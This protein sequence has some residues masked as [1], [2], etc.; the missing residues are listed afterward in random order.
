MTEILPTNLS[1]LPPLAITSLLILVLAGL[2]KVPFGYSLRNMLVRWRTTLV[3][4]L[5][6]T[7]V[8]GLLVVML[9]FVNGMNRL[10]DNTGSPAN[11]IILAE[12]ATDEVFSRMPNFHAD[13]LPSY[14]KE[15][16]ATGANDNYLVSAEV[17]VLVNQEVA[18]PKPGGPRRRFIQMRGVKDVDATARVHDMQLA[19]G[20]WFTDKIHEQD[21]VVNGEVVR[22]KE[23]VPEAVFG[24]GV[25]RVVG[26]DFF[27]RP[28]QP[29]DVV[30]VGPKWWH[31]TGVMRSEGSTFS[32]EV[33]TRDTPIQE[34]FGRPNSYSS[35]V[36][37]AKSPAMAQLAVQ[38]LKKERVAEMSLQPY[39]EREY[40]A[41]L[42][43]T[44]QQFSVAIYF[45]AVVMAIG[46]VLGVMN[47]MFAAIS[48]RQRDI[49]VLRLLGFRRGEILV[50]FLLE[51]VVIALLGGL[52]GCALGFLANG[53]SATSV[54]SSGAGGGGKSVV[55]R[56]IV[57]GNTV[58]IAL[59]FTVIM[60]FLGGLLPALSAMRLKPLESLR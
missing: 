23:P 50:C 49:G 6:F 37:R 22:A 19:S 8:I 26:D 60:G 7:L 18:N 28:L 51:S 39:T 12:G 9:A 41:K 24:E 58:A 34:N 42:N 16:L 3:T 36:A 46:G 1:L 54:V 55:L 17:Y 31:V 44:N 11:V 14:V 29:G 45:V 35:Y 32:S 59:V 43:R 52:L 56:L 40:Y 47:T 57:D 33:W 25:A 21:I 10:T 15:N 48:Q 27:G 38:V 30:K 53:L 13:Q 5:A 2:G 4:A 20:E